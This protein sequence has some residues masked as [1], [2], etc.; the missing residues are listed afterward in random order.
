M[1]PSNPR[2]A[3]FLLLL[4]FCLCAG[5]ATAENEVYLRVEV[6]EPYLDLYTGPGRGFPKFF[7]V[8]RGEWVE[9]LRR[10]TNW[11][12]VRTRRGK[13]GW[14]KRA[15]L[16]KTRSMSGNQLVFGGLGE[17]DFFGR[18]LEFGIAAGVL[19]EDPLLGVRGGYYLTDAIALELAFSHVPG[20]FSRSYLY[21]ANLL[22]Q[23]W[24]D[25]KYSPYF[26]LGAGTIENEPKSTLI[27]T[28]DTDATVWSAAVGVRG[29]ITRRFM[30]RLEA[31]DHVALVNEAN[32]QNLLEIT[33]GLSFFY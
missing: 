8:E 14:V 26:S 1:L 12:E 20:E 31:R 28:P 18:R 3:I 4:S 30:F 9:V 33:A 6:T 15:D 22:I 16:E 27:G 11:F 25:W 13:T 17:G 32:N 29:Y 10:R 5:N 2:S 21:T 24:S 23:P 7:A 19:E